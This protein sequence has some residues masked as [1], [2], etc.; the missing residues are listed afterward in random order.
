VHLQGLP[1]SQCAPSE[2]A[3]SPPRKPDGGNEGR[4]SGVQGLEQSLQGLALR[5][6]PGEKSEKQPT[7][8][9]SGSGG[10]SSPPSTQAESTSRALAQSLAARTAGFTCADLAALCKDAALMALRNHLA[11]AGPA[12]ADKL[13]PVT[14]ENFEETL[15][16]VFKRRGM[17]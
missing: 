17:I 11:S 12:A 14:A 9:N 8:L 7:T 16:T 2:N 4:T 15:G 13:P 5:D 3:T 6:E 1:L 10:V